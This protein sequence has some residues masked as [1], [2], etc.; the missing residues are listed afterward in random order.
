VIGAFG[1]HVGRGAR[2]DARRLAGLVL[3]R[4]LMPMAENR[5]DTKLIRAVQPD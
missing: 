5:A 2:A 1:D 4:L 3:P